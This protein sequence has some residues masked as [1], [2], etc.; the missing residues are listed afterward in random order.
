MSTINV[1]TLKA[2]SIIGANTS[3]GST[4]TINPNNSITVGANVFVNSSYISVGNSTVNTQVNTT[5]ISTSGLTIG[6]TFFNSV[7]D[8]NVNTQIFTSTGWSTWTKP[9]FATSGNVM[10]Q[11]VAWGGGSAGKVGVAS[12]AGGGGGACIIQT[13]D[14]GL[15]NATCNVFVASGGSSN[16]LAGEDSV[17][18]SNSTFAITAYGGGGSTTN[19]GG[20]GGGWFSKGSSVTGD[21]GGPLGGVSGLP[22]GDSTFGGGGTGQSSSRGGFSVYGGGGGG[23]NIG[24]GGNT[25][26]GGGGGGGTTG[27]GGV[28]I[29]GG[30]GAG[31]G[32]AASAP[33]GAG[34]GN[35]SIVA[36]ARGEVRVYTYKV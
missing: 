27:V 35:T 36:G 3:V 25:I 1:S 31:N 30:N 13:I 16:A 28:S 18:W 26:F 11:I 32:I 8:E 34:A 29:F 10:V 17:F 19:E 24:Q 4:V 9:S 14:A 6:A 7:P 23:R 22:G 5:A 12:P 20:A 33:G 15:C 2:E 21:G